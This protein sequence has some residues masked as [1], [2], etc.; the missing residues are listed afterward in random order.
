MN[1]AMLTGC[2]FIL[3]FVY[4]VIDGALKSRRQ[5]F[6]IAKE[7][8]KFNQKNKMEKLFDFEKDSGGPIKLHKRHLE[9]E[10]KDPRRVK[11]PD[12][13]ELDFITPHSDFDETWGSASF[14]PRVW[15]GGKRIHPPKPKQGHHW[16]AGTDK[17]GDWYFVEI[18]N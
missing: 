14:E 3:C 7:I 11:I 10:G 17:D 1:I 9:D 16:I 5:D 18:E 12:D 6:E 13:C 15:R 2:V 8:E 4:L